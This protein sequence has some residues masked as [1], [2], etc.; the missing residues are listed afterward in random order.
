MLDKDS[1]INKIINRVEIL[2]ITSSKKLGEDQFDNK[3]Y[4]ENMITEQV[5]GS[6]II[7]LTFPHNDIIYNQLIHKWIMKCV[8]IQFRTKFN[9]IP[10]Q[11]DNGDCY[12]TLPKYLKI[13]R[14]NGDIQEGRLIDN[15]GLYLRKSMSGID[16]K[17][18]I[19]VRVEYDSDV[20]RDIH[21][22]TG[23]LQLYKD[24]SLED[25]IKI[26][27]ITE[28]NIHFKLPDHL[29]IHYD[30]TKFLV[31]KYFIELHNKWYKDTFEPIINEFQKK[32]D[33]KI[34]IITEKIIV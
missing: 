30:S 12:H 10:T 20:F 29:A 19:K 15:A 17:L 14:T 24:C 22:V 13:Q 27:N 16:D 4:N 8:H 34:N 26:N 31:L 7:Q 23:K 21:T 3:F 28:F 32:Q 18:T 9:L 6:N 25:I 1:Y 11:I 2:G 33:I 5:Q